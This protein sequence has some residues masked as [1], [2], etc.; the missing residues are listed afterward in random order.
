MKTTLYEMY[1]QNTSAEKRFSNN[2]K[3]IFYTEF[4][5]YMKSAK[6]KMIHGVRYVRFDTI[7]TMRND[8]RKLANDPEWD[9][10]EIEENENEKMA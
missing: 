7:E 5:Y 6:E 9:F 8:W 1:L 4:L 3:H 2:Q 10:N